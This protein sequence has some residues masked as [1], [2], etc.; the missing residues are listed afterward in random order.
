MSVSTKRQSARSPEP[1]ATDDWHI[2]IDDIPRTLWGIIAWGDG[3][4]SVAHVTGTLNRD[5]AF[6]LRA[7][8]IGGQNRHR[9]QPGHDV[10]AQPGPLMAA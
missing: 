2:G 8:E 9:Y 1:A 6:A 5:R 10:M 4:Q 3:M 7:Q